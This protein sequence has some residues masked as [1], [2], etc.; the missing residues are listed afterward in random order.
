MLSEYL[1]ELELISELLD[2]KDRH[3]FLQTLAGFLGSNLGARRCLI[4]IQDDAG[5][6]L[7][8]WTAEPAV[9]DILLIKIVNYLARISAAAQTC[10]IINEKTSS[11][12][13]FIETLSEISCDIAVFG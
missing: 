10:L 1:N 5:E 7:V 9:D 3:D 6:N 12:K 13:K 11:S 8:E 4:Y 2:S